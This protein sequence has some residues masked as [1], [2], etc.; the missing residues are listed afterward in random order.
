MYTANLDFGVIPILGE[1]YTGRDDNANYY[2]V[3][4]VNKV[5]AMSNLVIQMLGFRSSK[6]RHKPCQVKSLDSCIA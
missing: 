5:D 4:V 1:G 6:A 2:S 3:A